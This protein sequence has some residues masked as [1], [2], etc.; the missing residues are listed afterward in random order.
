[1]PVL[2]E[3]DLQRFIQDGFI[4][5]DD[6]FPRD[7]ADEARA[8]LW[9]ET[10]L[11][12]DDPTT[13]TQPVVRLGNY[14]TETMRRAANTPRLHEAFDALVGPGRWLRCG[15]M[16]TFP[17]RFPSEQPPGDDGWHVDASFGPPD[18]ASFFD[19]RLNVASRGRALLMLFLFSDVGEHDAPTRIRV[20][21]HRDV[22]RI[23]EPHGEQGLS[24]MELANRLTQT[25][26]AP[27]ALA[28]GAAGT[29][30]LCHPFLAHAAQP[31]R[32]RTPRFMAQPPLLSNGEFH[33]DRAT[34]PGAP[35]EQAI[36]LAL[37][38]G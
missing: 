1:M 9:K 4:R 22:A 35:V 2:S 23:L 28:T 36:R 30:Y 21:S 8:F 20:G 25:E 14:A 33:I 12:P 7:L 13:W 6:A 11:S 26:G 15:S 27:E 17:V 10:G 24:F 29:V 31:H 19:W 5:L 37:G 34:E 18:A 3:A 38:R 32:G 16:G